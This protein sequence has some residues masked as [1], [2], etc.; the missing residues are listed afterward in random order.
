MCSRPTKPDEG[1]LHDTG[2]STLATDFAGKLDLEDDET[3][4]DDDDDDDVDD[5]DDAN[6]VDAAVVKRP[7]VA[8]GF[9][10]VLL[11]MLLVLLLL[12]QAV[13]ALLLLV[14]TLERSN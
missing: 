7:V 1:G 8:E 11:L 2:F 9:D 13:F 10:F 4:V 3:V 6:D 12:P 5:A 14:F